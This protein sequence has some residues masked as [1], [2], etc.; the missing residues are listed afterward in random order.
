[1][2]GSNML[3]CTKELGDYAEHSRSEAEA[4]AEQTGV[5][6][7]CAP[8][9]LEG[10]VNTSTATAVI[11][12]A[13]GA[14]EHN[15]IIYQGYQE[16]QESDLICPKCGRKMHKHKHQTRKVTHA[17]VNCSYAMIKVQTTTFACPDCGYFHSQKLPYQMEGARITKDCEAYIIDLLA[18]QEF[19]N[20]AVA[21]L[22]G[23][24][25]NT[26]WMID[27]SR[28]TD[29][30]TVQTE[31][32]K[33]ELRKPSRPARILTIDEFLLHH[34][35]QFAT[36]IA[37]YDTGEIL[38]IAKG[39]KKQVVY[40]FIE[41][42]GLEWMQNVQAVACDM[43]SDFQEAFQEKCPHI[44][45]VYDR[46]HIVKNLNEKVIDAIRKA[47]VEK[48]KEEGKEEEANLLKGTKYLLMQTKASR[49]ELDARA[50]AGQK[51]GTDSQ[52]FKMAS[53]AMRSDHQARY[54]AIIK[55]NEEFLTVDIIKEKIV[56]LY[57]THK[58]NEGNLVFNCANADEMR[59][60]MLDII[61]ICRGSECRPLIRF[62]KMIESH[63]DGIVTFANFHISSGKMEGINNRIKTLRRISYGISDDEYFFLKVI[64]MSC[65]K[66]QAKAAAEARRKDIEARGFRLAC[67]KTVEIL[68]VYA[69]PF[70]RAPY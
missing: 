22:T 46:F 42:V 7:L 32:G 38:W 20:T 43:N 62:A 55:N 52:L 56:Y 21:A 54:E 69:V 30:Y 2:E 19:S 47:K 65:S 37:D 40:D 33:R 57:G 16:V 28:L 8:S 58:D 48:L 13:S 9:N 68:G 61:S 11:R 31:D 26:I 50:I 53:H 35:N 41:H 39:K 23:V 29:K 34:K 5:S 45:I 49:E 4:I 64:D 60:G 70:A 14:I 10:F 6:W 63:M 59:E 17:P 24:C 25:R 3:N 67:S 44:E 51:R 15:L 27:K 66:M 18:R 36:H 1:M 12:D